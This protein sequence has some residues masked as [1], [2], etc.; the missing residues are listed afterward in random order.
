MKWLSFVTGYL[1]AAVKQEA[2]EIW[3]DALLRAGAKW[4]FEIERKLRECD[5]L[6]LL[7]S[8]HS[9]SSDYVVDK[10]LAIVRERQKNGEDV[11]I[12]PLLLTPTPKIALELVNDL[13][14]RP[15]DGKPFWRVIRFRAQGAH[16]R[17][18]RRDR[19]HRRAEIGARPSRPRGRR[20]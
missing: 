2:I 8:H 10:E 11:R 19:G 7:C 3:V 15:R 16:G 18:G 4:N 13:V 12:V 6:V 20:G 5:I 17:G 9:L 14:I 1:R